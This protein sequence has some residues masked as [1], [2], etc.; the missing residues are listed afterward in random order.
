MAPSILSFPMD[1]YDWL[2]MLFFARANSA[3]CLPQLKQTFA[4]NLSRF[5]DGVCVLLLDSVSLTI[6]AAH[7]TTA[8]EEIFVDV[9]QFFLPE[10]VLVQDIGG[11]HFCGD[12][13]SKVL[14]AFS[15]ESTIDGCVIAMRFCVRL[16]QQWQPGLVGIAA[17][18]KVKRTRT[19]LHDGPVLLLG[20]LAV[21][22]LQP[23]MATQSSFVKVFLDQ[24]QLVVD[25]LRYPFAVPV[26]DEAIDTDLLVARD[27][28]V[29]DQSRLVSQCAQRRH[30]PAIPVVTLPHV[31]GRGAFD[32]KLRCVEDVFDSL[33]RLWLQGSATIC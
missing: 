27:T 10:L 20:A 32:E 7:L 17:L 31:V 15:D 19:T 30:E 33:D 29:L 24:V 18:R 25:D 3:D 5:H 2:D 11:E 21:L 16:L 22:Q 12:T 13:S 4:V 14:Y 26:E 28:N 6:N 23:L 1:S 9:H 8:K